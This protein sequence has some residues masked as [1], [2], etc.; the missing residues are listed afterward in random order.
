MLAW[1]KYPQQPPSGRV[2]CD[3]CSS[4]SSW[5]R[6]VAALNRSTAMADLINLLVCFLYC[7]RVRLLGDAAKQ[8]LVLQ[9]WTIFGSWAVYSPIM[10]L[11]CVTQISCRSPAVGHGDVL[12]D[13]SK[14]STEKWFVLILEKLLKNLETK[15]VQ[16]Q[17]RF[18]FWTIEASLQAPPFH[19]CECQA[20]QSLSS[21]VWNSNIH[22]APR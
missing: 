14:L 18:V 8:M 10:F 6:F 7:I 22:I 13:D 2:A 20:C 4:S 16:C 1:W 3:S 15:R 19:L 17:P 12:Q 11:S 9:H 21:Y 5:K